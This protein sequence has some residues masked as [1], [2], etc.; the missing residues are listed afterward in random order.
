MDG[1]ADPFQAKVQGSL[2][3]CLKPGNDEQKSERVDE[4]PI[5][6]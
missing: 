4:L 2:H 5:F 3:Q 6:H 1:G